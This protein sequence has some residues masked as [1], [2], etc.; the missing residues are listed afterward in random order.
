MSFYWASTALAGIKAGAVWTA[1][2]V[3]KHA[4][5]ITNGN[6]KRWT[7]FSTD[8][9]STQRAMWVILEQDPELKHVHSIPCNSHGIQL[10]LKDILKPG[11]DQQKRQISSEIS[12]FFA[13]GLNAIV[14]AFKKAPKQ[15]AILWDIMLTSFKKIRALISTVPTRWGTQ[16][17]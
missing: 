9:D 5:D 12:E 4:L 11:K 10:I 15:L 16:V 17:A 14:T 1:A 3:R 2:N 6:L 13:S 8:I 7:A